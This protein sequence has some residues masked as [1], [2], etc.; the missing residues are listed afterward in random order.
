MKTPPTTKRA[1]A[2]PE[3]VRAPDAHEEAVPADRVRLTFHIVL[4]RRLAEA[5]SAEASRR[6]MDLRALVT[7]LLGMAAAKAL[8]AGR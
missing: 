3:A 6:E 5:L 1:K 7:E 2:I 8:H 4:P